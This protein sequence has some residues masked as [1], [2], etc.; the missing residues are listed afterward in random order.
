MAIHKQSWDKE[1]TILSTMIGKTIMDI[2]YDGTYDAPITFKLSDGREITI[3]AA[4]DDMAHT[5]VS[6]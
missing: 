4:G 5:V 3:T 6:D 1:A 2:T